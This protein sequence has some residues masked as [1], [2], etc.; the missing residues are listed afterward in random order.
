[1]TKI[2]AFWAFGGCVFFT[3]SCGELEFCRKGESRGN[4]CH[5]G[6]RNLEAVMMLW[7]WDFFLLV[8][9]RSFRVSDDGISGRGQ[10]AGQGRKGQVNWRQPLSIIESR[11]ATKTKEG[12]TK[13]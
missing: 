4:P 8:L 13:C 9:L 6:L 12:E 5:C 2:L 10:R 1:M 11:K 7:I 3:G